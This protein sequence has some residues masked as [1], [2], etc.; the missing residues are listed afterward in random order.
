MSS[1]NP[2]K[3]LV[4]NHQNGPMALLIA[5]WKTPHWNS[6]LVPPAVQES[7]AH[8]KRPRLGS[9]S[10]MILWQ[11][12]TSELES[13]GTSWPVGWYQP[14]IKS[15]RSLVTSS[16]NSWNNPAQ[17][18]IRAS[19]TMDLVP[20]NLVGE[21]GIGLSIT[22]AIPTSISYL[23]SVCIVWSLHLQFL[24]L[25]EQLATQDSLGSRKFQGFRWAVRPHSCSNEAL[26][27]W[28]GPGVSCL[29]LVDMSI[30]W[31]GPIRD[32]KP[33]SS[34][35]GIPFGGVGGTH[36]K[37]GWASRILHSYVKF[38]LEGDDP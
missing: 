31:S 10:R 27:W 14:E 36:W 25:L 28:R 17:F 23:P 22:I 33:N 16:T 18:N 11:L 7:P 19:T 9:Y 2:M 8:I 34:L 30:S 1:L 13:A 32:Y 24:G 4:N 15:I 35:W 37:L 20:N 3:Y 12:V 38:P 26:V 5:V 29:N 21:Q 6:L